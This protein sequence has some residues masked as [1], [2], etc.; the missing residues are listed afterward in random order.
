MPP[1]SA[2]TIYT[3]TAK[4]IL[5]V[6]NKSVKL[7]R[8]LGLIFLSVDGKASVGDLQPRSGMTPAQLQHALNT[9]VTDGY[10]K[11]VGQGVPQPAANDDNVDFTQKQ[12][13]AS[14]NAEAASHALAASDATK[15]AQAEAKAA[16]ES[17]LRQEAEA[18]ARALAETRAASEA[19]AKAKAEQAARA[20]AEERARADRDAAGTTEPALRAEAEARARAA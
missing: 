6:K 11:V 2:E 17:R 15:R 4:G 20:A 14:V 3:K 5:E 13:V 12:V 10:I 8:E 18:R 16:L 19:E 7:P 1:I 9:L